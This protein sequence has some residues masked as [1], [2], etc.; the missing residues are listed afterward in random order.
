MTAQLPHGSSRSLSAL[1]K[2]VVRQLAGGFTPPEIAKLL[3]VSSKQIRTWLE[4]LSFADEVERTVANHDAAMQDYL[5]YGE[6][7][8]VSTA[9]SVMQGAVDY[10]G[11]VDYKTR[12]QA[13]IEF[14]NRSGKRGAPVQATENKNLTLT[15]NM[16]NALATALRDP[17]VRDWLDKEPDVLKSL[18]T[19]TTEVPLAAPKPLSP[20]PPDS[21][22][23]IISD[24]E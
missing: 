1:Q 9:L 10:K 4:D 22:F 24:E 5:I 11:N 17:G 6:E 13:A 14:L 15:G 2:A 19:G 16:D 7:I 23:E 12:L 20:I 21:D 3:R 18:M 8:A